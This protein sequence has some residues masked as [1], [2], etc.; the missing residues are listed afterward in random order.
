[1]EYGVGAMGSFSPFPN[2]FEKHRLTVK[3]VPT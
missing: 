3:G 1:M 2:F